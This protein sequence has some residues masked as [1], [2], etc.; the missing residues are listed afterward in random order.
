MLVVLSVVLQPYFQAMAFPNWSSKTMVLNGWGVVN[1]IATPQHGGPAF[2]T[3]FTTV[4]GM[5]HV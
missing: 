3:G 4:E 5:A 2:Y 1:S